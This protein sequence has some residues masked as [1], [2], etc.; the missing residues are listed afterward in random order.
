MKTFSPLEANHMRTFRI[1]IAAVLLTGLALA[2][3]ASTPGKKTPA[4]KKAPGQE[5]GQIPGFD[6]SAL[7]KTADPCVDFYQYSC[8]G[9]INKNPIPADQALWGRFNELAERNRTVL[10]EILEKAA[11]D[12][13][14]DPNEQKI[15]DYY[16]SCMD[17]AGIDKKGIAVLKPEFDRIDALKDKNELPALLAHLHLEGIPVLFNFGSGPDFKNAKE[18]IGQADQGGL[19]LPDRDYYLKDDPKSVE[20]RKA[21]QEHVANMFKLLGDSPD[22]AAAEAQ[23]VMNVETALAK[24]AMDRVERRD[25]EKV[26]HKLSEQDWQA[27]T[28]SFSLSKYLTDLGSPSI[29]SFNVANP[30]FFKALDAELK[31]LSLDDLKTYLRWHLVHSQAQYLP[32]PFVNENFNSLVRRSRVQRNCE[33]AGSG[34]SPSQMAI[35]VKPWAG[36]LWKRTSLPRPRRALLRW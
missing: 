13:K 12:T 16:A 7:D 1:V 21:Y 23:A 32:M 10:R 3:D 29:T 11:K 22:K 34:V 18:V 15:G 24:G 4:G 19:S 33:R 36:S 5:T 14:R 9:W 25:P 2:Q 31:N 30:E 28:P 26:Y 6:A 20:L 27:L 8:G 17:E 35:W